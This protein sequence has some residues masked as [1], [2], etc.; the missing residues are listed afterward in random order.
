METINQDS[1]ADKLTANW[2]A[3]S[4]DKDFGDPSTKPVEPVKPEDAINADVVVPEEPKAPE[5]VKEE[6]KPAEPAKVEPPKPAEEPIIDP[7]SIFDAIEGVPSTYP[8]GSYRAL[9]QSLG[10]EIDEESIDA[11]K[12]KYVSKTEA[13]KIATNTK[14]ELF[15]TLTP[16]VAAAFQLKELGI[17]DELLLQPT[18]EIDGYLALDDAELFRADK[19][20]T[21]GWTPEMID[22]EI[23][24]LIE[25]NKLT[26][27]SQKIRIELNGQKNNILAS[28]DNLVQQYTQERQAVIVR[29][30]EQEKTQVK[31]ALG[32]VLSFAG[33]PI[34]QKAK[35]D[36]ILKYNN[37]LYDKYL[38]GADV[39]ANY[40]IMKELEAKITKYVQST[41][42][43]RAKKEVTDKLLNIPPLKA[44]GGSQAAQ[45][46]NQND[47]WGPLE[48]DFA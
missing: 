38:S 39:K 16:E 45:P 6:S 18:K 10:E 42:A 17:P 40:I 35:D 13:S 31:E 43:A 22:I 8:A 44:S 33:V 41:A 46:S 9:A 48:R 25:S 23:E 32:K 20:A 5:P 7:E 21:V 36:I 27:E 19:M 28:K 4:F 14:E 2:D 29:Q 3:L 30:R 26:H 15:A 37:G 24:N 11:F 1:P 34:P 47:N 12:A